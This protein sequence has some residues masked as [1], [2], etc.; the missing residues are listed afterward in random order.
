MSALFDINTII[1]HFLTNHAQFIMS[2]LSYIFMY[3]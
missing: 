1:H 2:M 3:E